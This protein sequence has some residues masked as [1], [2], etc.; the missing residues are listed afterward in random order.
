[1]AWN[2]FGFKVP[3]KKCEINKECPRGRYGVVV[4]PIAGHRGIYKMTVKLTHDEWSNHKMV[5]LMIGE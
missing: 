2:K 1:M 3:V 5:S 4:K